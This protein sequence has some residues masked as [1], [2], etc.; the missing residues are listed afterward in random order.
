MTPPLFHPLSEFASP[1]ASIA[2]RLSAIP[3]YHFSYNDIISGLFCEI[4]LDFC[5]VFSE[6]NAWMFPFIIVFMSL[7]NF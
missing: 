6:I 5:V 4:V 7:F 2:K 3:P 1:F